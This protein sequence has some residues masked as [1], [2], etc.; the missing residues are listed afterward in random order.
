M[1][2]IHIS[3]KNGEQQ[4]LEQ[5][6]CCVF[7][8]QSGKIGRFAGRIGVKMCN[9]PSTLPSSLFHDSRWDFE[10]EFRGFCAVPT[11]FVGV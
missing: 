4:H 1:V 7:F 6:K 2:V 5:L 11:C 9:S 10:G 3:W 8:G